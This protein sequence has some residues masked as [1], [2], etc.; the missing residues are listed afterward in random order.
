[1]LLDEKGDTFSLVD[2]MYYAT[3]VELGVTSAFYTRLRP[4][5]EQDALS[6]TAISPRAQ[7]SIATRLSKNHA[8]RR[9]TCV[10]KELL[11]VV[12]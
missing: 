11:V 9:H 5:A 4:L 6:Y 8:G 2:W 7:T 3:P 12:I 10:R 1:M